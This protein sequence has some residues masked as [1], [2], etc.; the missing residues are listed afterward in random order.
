MTVGEL[1]AELKKFKKNSYVGLSSCYNKDCPVR[2][3][4]GDCNEKGCERTVYQ[5]C[6]VM[7][8][9]PTEGEKNQWPSIE[10]EAVD[11]WN[12]DEDGEIIQNH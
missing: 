10:I 7:A 1:I 5:P 6:Y 12:Y 9:D 2:E 8:M 4:T 11:G 3:N